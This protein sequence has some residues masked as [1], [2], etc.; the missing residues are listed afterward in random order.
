[1][2]KIYMGFACF[3][4]EHHSVTQAGGQ[5]CDISSMQ[6]LPPRFKRFSC[7]SLLNNWDYRSP[8]PRLANF[9]VFSRDRV[10]PYCTGWSATPDLVIHSPW[11][12]KVLGLQNCILVAQ[13]GM[14]CVTSAHYNLHLPGAIETGFHHVGQAALELLTL[15]DLSASAFQSAGTTGVSHHSWPL[16]EISNFVVFLSGE[17]IQNPLTW[18]GISP[19]VEEAPRAQWNMMHPQRWSSP[20]LPG[21][22]QTHDLVI[23]LPGPPK[24]LG[25]ES[26]YVARLECS[27]TISAHCNLRLSLPRIW[28]Y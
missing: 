27:G 25:L 3:E 19:D 13:A 21:W 5:W 8:P 9:C 20:C 16:C 23:H 18:A 22:S 7:L 24:V 6:P 2:V 12:P 14:Q 26:A 4:K 11:P 15:G 28:D 10:S 1:M 17:E